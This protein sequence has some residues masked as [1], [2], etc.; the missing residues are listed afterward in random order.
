[1]NKGTSTAPSFPFLKQIAT[2]G[3][4]AK[5]SSKTNAK[6]IS[7]KDSLEISQS[8]RCASRFISLRN[9]NYLSRAYRTSQLGNNSVRSN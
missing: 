8:P 7:S 6:A 3:Y 5:Y 4:I 9:P 2:P 1:M